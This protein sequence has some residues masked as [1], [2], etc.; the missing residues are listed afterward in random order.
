MNILRIS[1]EDFQRIKEIF[2]KE[3]NEQ[4]IFLLAEK[5][6]I[7]AHKI[8]Y[9]V[10][11]VFFPE[12]QDMKAHHSVY[13][14]PR[15]EF[16]LKIYQIAYANNYSI[17][18]IHN[19]WFQNK[20]CFSSIDLDSAIENGNFIS[21][22]LPGIDFGLAVFNGDVNIYSGKIFSKV[23]KDFDP[24]DS[25][26]II[27][28]PIELL[29]NEKLNN[30]TQTD[31]K[32]SRHHLIPGFK[33]DIL[34]DL[35]VALVGAGGTGSLIVQALA[36]LGIGEGK[37]MLILIDPDCIEKSNL[38]RIP[39]A[40][41]MDI[42][43]PKVKAARQY[44]KSK[45]PKIK[46]IAIPKSVQEEKVQRILKQAHIIL[47]AVDSEGARKILT[48]ISEQACIPYI[49]TGTEIIPENQGYHAGGQVRVMLP[50]KGCLICI[51]GIDLSEAALDLLCKE[52]AKDYEKVGYIR[53]TS[54]TPTPSV[55]HLNGVISYL[56]IAQFIKLVFGENLIGQKTVFYDQQKMSLLSADFGKNPRCPLCGET[57]G[58]EE[59]NERTGKKNK[60]FQG[61]YVLP[62][63]ASTGDGDILPNPVAKPHNENDALAKSGDNDGK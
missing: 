15:K 12:E 57:F 33:Q 36:G 54:Q 49:D 47:G 62:D 38:P 43:K 37:G 61:N 14:E 4:F 39:Y 34:P 16:Q 20:P 41:P 2:Q 56:A 51:N 44:I 9:L 52:K 46:V 42:A 31:E 27:G 30:Q 13:V 1:R 50:G 26:E 35:K 23:K 10:K 8:I 17:F 22:Y 58:K 18:D 24:I 40:F 60:S 6:R 11:R 19:H 53:G 45:N 7:S 29:F 25:I 28:S 48:Q 63:D 5:I 55:I 59:E 3:K 21:R 32:Y